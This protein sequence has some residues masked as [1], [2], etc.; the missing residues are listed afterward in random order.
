MLSPQL[1]FMQCISQISKLPRIER[2]QKKKLCCKA[3]VNSIKYQRNNPERKRSDKKN[4]TDT[5]KKKKQN[6]LLRK[7]RQKKNT[8][9]G[10]T[11]TR[12]SCI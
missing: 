8:Y 2:K 7:I 10:K 6:K 12:A 9:P 3:S 11:K 1:Q 5:T 4:M